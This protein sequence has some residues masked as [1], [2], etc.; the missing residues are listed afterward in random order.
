MK[1]YNNY[2][3]PKTL[4]QKQNTFN[5]NLSHVSSVDENDKCELCKFQS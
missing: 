2:I 5:I 4:N 1:C 3:F